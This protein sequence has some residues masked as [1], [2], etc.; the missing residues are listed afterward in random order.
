[1]LRR[2]SLRLLSLCLNR[3]ALTRTNMADPLLCAWAV[4]SLGRKLR[5]LKEIRR[6]N[7]FENP[8]PG[9]YV[10]RNADEFLFFAFSTFLNLAVSHSVNLCPLFLFLFIFVAAKTPD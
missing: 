8:A 2:N 6:L 4:R 10:L 7:A 9:L 3:G 1:M 5:R